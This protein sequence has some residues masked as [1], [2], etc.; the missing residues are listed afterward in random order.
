M[1]RRWREEKWI[2]VRTMEEGCGAGEDGRYGGKVWEE[3][4]EERN[5]LDW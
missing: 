2:G 1:V 3:R 5:S 4:K